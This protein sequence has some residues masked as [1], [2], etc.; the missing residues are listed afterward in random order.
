MNRLLFSAA[1]RI[2]GAGVNGIFF[3]L[4]PTMLIMPPGDMVGAKGGTSIKDQASR[5]KMQYLQSQ[6]HTALIHGPT[7]RGQRAFFKLLAIG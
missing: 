6:S 4:P 5:G 1:T 3:F 2:C 7:R